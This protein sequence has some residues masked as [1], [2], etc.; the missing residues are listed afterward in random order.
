MELVKGA[1]SWPKCSLRGFQGSQIDSI[2]I[3]TLW[4][5]T[6]RNIDVMASTLRNID[7]IASTFWNINVMEYWHYGISML[8]N[9]NIMEYQCYGILT[10]WN[11]DVMEY[12]HYGISTLGIS[13]IWD[14]DV[15]VMVSTLWTST[16]WISNL[17]PCVCIT[18]RPRGRVDGSCSEG[19]WSD[20]Q[21]KHKRFTIS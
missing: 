17:G 10:L 15:D 20:S 6:L 11:V 21:V 16:L 9:I 1:R 4:M 8:W 3:S 7:V 2:E 13:T 14:V 19:P 18:L 5:S 12:Q